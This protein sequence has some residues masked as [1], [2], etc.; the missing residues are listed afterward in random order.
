M[1]FLATGVVG[2]E[3]PAFRAEVEA[4]RVG[5]EDTFALTITIEGR[6][7]DLKG[8]IS[9]PE[10]QNLQ[11]VGGPSTSTRVSFVNG[12][13][14]QSRQYTLI[15]QPSAVGPASIGPVRATLGDQER[16]T[17]PIS[18]EVV[19]GSVVQA[20]PRPV[21]PFGRGAGDPLEAMFGRQRA[22]AQRAKVLV[23]AEPS[24]T[25]VFVGEPVLVTYYLFTQAAI[26][27]LDLDGAPKYPGFW[28][29]ELP[30]KDE[31]PRGEQ[32]QRDGEPF[33]RF[34]VLQKLLYPTKSGTLEIPAVRFRLG[35]PQRQDFFDPFPGGASVVN[36]ATE[37]LRITVDPIPAAPGMAGAVGQLQ[38]TAT[39]DRN[40]VQVGE[41]ATLRFKV[42][43]T[44]NLR[45]IEHGPEVDIPGVRV[46]PPQVKTDVKAAPSGLSGSRTWEYVLIPETA[47]THRVP[48][49]TFSHLDLGSRRVVQTTTEPLELRVGAT[50]GS[51]A[52]PVTAA[53]R[54]AAPTGQGGELRLRAELEPRRPLV[55]GA[56]PAALSVLVLVAVF[57]HVLLWG[58]P[59]LGA[60]GETRA[61]TAH[62]RS[63]RKALADLRRVARGDLSKEAAAVL[64][65]QCLLELFG[66]LD[67]RPADGDGE[68]EQELK[69]ILQDAR[70]VR[71]A[72]QL[73]DYS[74]KLR[75][76]VDRAAGAIR[77]W[78]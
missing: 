59:R 8:E 54:A 74:D 28:V 43:G 4:T 15:L 14:S 47:G 2:A 19:A 23:A 56:S 31:Q 21:D 69:A 50:P 33:Q 57:G 75:E 3:G 52:A 30:R 6:S 41:A 72:P 51:P 20:R 61:A 5:L 32:V 67:E 77:R 26:A 78:A 22:P 48:A 44:G 17:D 39:L 58:W 49:L 46:Y 63:A 71:Y 60:L 27:G 76:V 25:R 18:I 55:P 12:T 10:L 64:V 38:A 1:T 16:A 34:V 36:R 37:P 42:A 24:R 53:G 35:I 40:V 62:G 45:W 73:G 68:R 29:E 65:E 7:I 11:I 13:I 9:T 66:P 70:F